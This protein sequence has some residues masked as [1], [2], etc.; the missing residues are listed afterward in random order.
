ME[1]KGL[2]RRRASFDGEK[3]EKV[4][5]TVTYY[6]MLNTNVLWI[7]VARERVGESDIFILRKTSYLATKYFVVCWRDRLLAHCP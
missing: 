6:V 4:F 5:S 2:Q 7:I 3:T 1:T